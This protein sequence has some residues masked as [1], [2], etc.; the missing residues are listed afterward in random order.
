MALFRNLPVS[1]KIGAG[2][3]AVAALLVA[4][5]SIGLQ[6]VKKANDIS[7]R[8]YEL[9]VP[10]TQASLTLL[11][12]IDRSLAALRGWMLLGDNI[13]V[14]EREQAWSS[15]IDP[16]F[17]QLKE[18]SVHWTDR[19]NLERLRLIEARLEDFRRYQQEIEQ[20]ANTTENRPALRILLD[21][22]A[23]AAAVMATSI[24]SL[25]DLE[26]EQEATPE[27]KALLGMMADVRGTIGLGL[28]SLRA[29]ILSGDVKYR[30]QFDRYWSR[31]ARR[32]GDLSGQQSLFTPEQAAAYA[33]LKNSRLQ[34]EPLPN[35]MFRIRE[36]AEWNIANSWLGT[37]A[38][39][40]AAVIRQEL[41][42]M[43]VDQRTLMDA[44]MKAANVESSSLMALQRNAL[45]IGSVLC[46]L[47]TAYGTLVVRGVT[48]P[49]R[50]AVGNMTTLSRHLT[51][52]SDEIASAGQILAQGASEQAASL[53][54]T[55]AS[56]EELAATSKQNADNARQA[57][58]LALRATTA[59]DQGSEA[60]DRMTS[61]I[62]KIK[63]SSDE[64]VKIVKDID[65]IAFQTNLLALNAAVEAARAGEAG[66]G[67]AVVAEEVR[68]LARRSAEAA[69]N[70]STLLEEAKSNSDE[71]VQ[72][73]KEVQKIL[74][75]ISAH[76]QETT[77]L[78]EG[79][80]SSSED[81]AKGVAEI[82]IAVAQMD[83]VTQSLAS[84]SEE[85][86]AASQEL[87]SQTN[88]I[89]NVTVRL[90]AI[91]GNR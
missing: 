75:A 47:L 39:P 88:E 11:N 20:I 15:D 33:A 31:N 8:V 49:V 69:G 1:V 51:A 27:R 81:Q 22:A 60:M 66:K 40:T 71:G 86:A 84:T 59:G 62:A 24:T 41:N 54:Q 45:I 52:S 55:S 35:R 16:A 26:A 7:G 91:L 18:N 12:G 89:H 2:Y 25:I 14:Q 76:V 68:N 6:K 37:R 28:A 64:T 21:E 57:N 34:F 83:K 70:T 32:F 42:A 82:N 17:A 65:E 4:S 48:R 58:D 67:F 3:A 61:A 38:A 73:S 19:M 10:T 9:R 29:Y 74:A 36:G 63:V 85:T 53:E 78:V 87:S 44:D 56:L 80:A 46:L 72:V 5:S 50:D 43:I 30:N 23:P 90:G 77:T 13:F 79:I